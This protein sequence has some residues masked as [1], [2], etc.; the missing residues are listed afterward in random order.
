MYGDMAM[1]RVSSGDCVGPT[2]C[3]DSDASCATFGASDDSGALV[4]AASQTTLI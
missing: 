3:G 4:L 1:S 2:V